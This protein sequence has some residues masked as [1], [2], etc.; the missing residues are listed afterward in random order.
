MEKILAEYQI[1]I[2]ITCYPTE[3]V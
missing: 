3:T 1:H 2:I